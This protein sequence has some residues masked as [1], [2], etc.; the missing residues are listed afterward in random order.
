MI[1]ITFSLEAD[2]YHSEITTL[3]Y[4]L[5]DEDPGE[6]PITPGKI[7]LTFQECLAH[8]D[9]TMMLV[10]KSGD[11][12]VGYA[13]LILFWSNEYGGNILNI[14]EF[15]IASPYRNLGIGSH[16]ISCLSS[17][18]NIVGFPQNQNIIG[19][20]LET[21]P[22]NINAERLY[23][24]LGFLPTVNHTYFKPTEI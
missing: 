2:K 13:L 19:L 3:M 7:R 21:T 6:L 8:P 17:G 12:V 22:S 4:H 23:K 9:K 16:L 20:A 1:N 14:D 11:E 10:I 24:K 15:Y 18:F 5:Y